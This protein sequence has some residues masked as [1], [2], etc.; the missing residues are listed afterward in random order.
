MTKPTS[1]TELGLTEAMS[2]LEV[3]AEWF[4]QE[5]VDLEAAL[6]KL[7]RGSLLIQAAKKQ[8]KTAENELVTIKEEL[9]EVLTT[10]D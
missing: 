6:S 8:L 3:I 1:Q 4:Q 9:N 5:N 7:K 10:T 2:E